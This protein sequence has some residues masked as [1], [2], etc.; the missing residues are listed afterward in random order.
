M[1]LTTT[2]FAF[3]FGNQYNAGQRCF[4]AACFL[5]F[6]EFGIDIA[7]SLTKD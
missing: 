4:L 7:Y 1:S 3:I 6:S 2:E 5:P